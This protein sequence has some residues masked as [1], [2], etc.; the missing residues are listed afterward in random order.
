MPFQP[1][2]ISTWRFGQ[3]AN[4][5]A[6]QTLGRGGTALDA[7]EQGCNEIELDPL[8]ADHSVG[9]AG[10]PNAKGEVTLDAMIMDGATHQA[11]AVGCLKRIKPAISVARKVMEKTKH[12]MLVG[13]DATEFARAM[14]FKEERLYSEEAFRKWEQWKAQPNHDTLGMVA[15]DARGN[16]AA[17][18][19]TSGIRGK[20]PGRVGDTPIIG[21][22]AYVDN[23]VGGAAGTGDGDVMMRFLLSF[24]VVELMR[25]GLAP[26]AAC[27]TALQRLTDK[28]LNPMACVIALNKNGNCGGAKIGPAAFQYAVRSPMEDKIYEQA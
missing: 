4:A 2:V 14:G 23:A 8:D 28:G 17:G 27:K 6:W 24:H 7:V 1:I 19:T 10:Y 15:M 16:F 5:K 18:C 3:R 20:V 9:W 22:G 25:Q 12:T 21:A 26:M 13:D 11:G